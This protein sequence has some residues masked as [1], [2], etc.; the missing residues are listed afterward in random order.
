M[1]VG[2][3]V[4]LAATPEQQPLQITDLPLEQNSQVK[5]NYK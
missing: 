2:D 4:I 3:G 5:V 1:H